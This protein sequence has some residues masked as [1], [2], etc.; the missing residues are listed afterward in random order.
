[1]SHYLI[2]QIGAPPN[3][4]VRTCSEVVEAGG[5]DHLEQLR[6]ADR[7]AGTEEEV[8]ASWLFVFIG[9]A[10]CTEWLGKEVRRDENGF[11]LTGPDLVRRA[12]SL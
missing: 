4:R 8:D 10:P 1:M 2:E 3:V 9:A 11:V 12:A 6:I 5:R 7:V